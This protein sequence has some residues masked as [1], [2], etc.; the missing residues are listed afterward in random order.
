L[1]TKEFKGHQVRIQL[2]ALELKA[3]KADIES[4]I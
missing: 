3:T 4:L 2:P 1:K